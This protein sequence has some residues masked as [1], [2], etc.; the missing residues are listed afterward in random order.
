[1]KSFLETFGKKHSKAYGIMKTIGYSDMLERISLMT[2]HG[3][4][5][6]YSLW[7]VST[8]KQMIET[9]LRTNPDAANAF[10]ASAYLD[11]TCR[12]CTGAV[13]VLVSAA[14]VRRNANFKEI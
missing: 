9:A 11:V 7:G 1:M 5:T 8:H 13:L 14:S 3:V 12:I 10:T 6:V 4:G 2:Y